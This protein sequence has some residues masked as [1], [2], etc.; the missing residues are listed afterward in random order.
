MVPWA[1]AHL[2]LSP[3]FADRAI[4]GLSA[5]AFG[6]VDLTLRHPGMF[7]VAESWSGYFQP[8]RD[9]PLAH[10]NA[11]QL[12]AHNPTL[13]VRREAPALRREHVR[14]FLSTGFNHGGIFRRWT[15]Q[16]ASELKSLRIPHRVWASQHPDRGRYLRLQLPAALE[17]AFS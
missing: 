13:L 6:A 15:F 9:G 1:N 16:F 14:F 12:A 5:G 7:G 2:P 8:F 10:A 17:Y 4:A 3:R 11:A